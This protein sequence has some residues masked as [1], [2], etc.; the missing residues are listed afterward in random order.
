MEYLL[1]KSSLSNWLILVFIIILGL[2][3]SISEFFQTPINS[4]TELSRYRSLFP[5]DKLTNLS[6]IALTN[7]IGTFR[8]EKLDGQPWELIYPRKFPANIP[9]LNTII[10]SL[11]NI[12]IRKVYQKDPINMANFSL[13]APLLEITIIE[14]DG[15][16]SKLQIGLINPIDNSTYAMISTQ[17]AIYHIDALKHPMS[18]LDLAD[19]ID[20][21][22][23]TFNPLK[24]ASL[25]IY[26]GNKS[27]NAVQLQ[28]K[29]TPKGWAGKNGR[30]LQNEKVIDY[31]TKLRNLKSNFILDKSSVKQTEQVEKFLE[32]PAYILEV[33]DE[34][35]NYFKYK[36][37]N[38]IPAIDKL[39]IERWQNFIITASDRKYPYLVKRDL[40][41][42]FTQSE[43]PL[44]KLQF[45]K[46][47][48]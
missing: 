28:L 3:A 32:K 23:F 45:K 33:E 12:K 7:R 29:K 36:I 35:K 4:T 22:I 25:K 31:L 11:Q 9:T 26:R 27:Q 37:S 19:F 47:F 43:K 16:K 48:Y 24:T 34:N 41:R 40:I 15:K 1:K 38:V 13:D 6:E 21:H 18:G 17:K 14:K 20:S 8:F 44:R 5:G 46:L 30:P 42:L 39:K 10:N 2:G